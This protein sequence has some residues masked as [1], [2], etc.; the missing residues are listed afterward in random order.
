M[1][2]PFIL[3]FIKGPFASEKDKAE[4][5]A[6][7]GAKVAFRNALAVSSEPHCLETCDGVAGAVPPIYAK[8]FPKAEVAVKAYAEGLQALSAKVGDVPAPKPTPF[9]NPNPP[10]KPA[11]NPN[12]NPPA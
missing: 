10:A 5:E 6:I 1:K 8:A 12:P 3:F 4:K 2:L 9:A 7:T 11:W